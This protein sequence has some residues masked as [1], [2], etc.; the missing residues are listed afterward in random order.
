MIKTVTTP[1]AFAA[2]GERWDEMVAQC[3]TSTPYQQHSL[4]RLSWEMWKNDGDELYIICHHKKE[5]WPADAIFPCYLRNGELHWID[6]HCDFDCPLDV[7]PQNER[8]EMY[9]EVVEH[10]QGNPAIAMVS[11]GRVPQYSPL[12]GYFSAM[13][14]CT[15][16]Q[17]SNAYSVIPLLD[18]EADAIASIATLVKQKQRKIKDI[19]RGGVKQTTKLYDPAADSYPGS[20][21]VQLADHMV[22]EGIRDAAY[23]SSHFLSF[24][25]RLYEA[26]AIK[27]LVSYEEG[28]PVAS[29]FLLHD[30]HRNELIEWVLLYKHRRYN[31]Q[32]MVHLLGIMKERGIAR[33]NLAC[34]IYGYKMLNFHPEVHC[35]YSV[36]M[37][38]THAD[39]RRH[40]LRTLL[41]GA[42]RPVTYRLTRMLKRK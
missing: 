35:V 6:F 22:A 13:G 21:I 9:A 34:G 24:F 41:R 27:V 25:Q 14:G 19:A 1:E 18:S 31:L 29:F 20:D 42:L 32:L 15:K 12:L 30:A 39:Y 38:R 5:E 40:E 23:M 11:F 7:T 10:I 17:A 2:L 37:W 3:A 36:R 4:C 8:Y 26:G 16:I 33:L 28:T